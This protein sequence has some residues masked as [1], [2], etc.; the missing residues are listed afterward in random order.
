MAASRFVVLGLAHARSAW[1]DEVARW[2]TSAAL[3]VE[4]VKAMSPEEVR[5]RIRSGRGHSALLVDASLVGLDR[6]LVEGA[7]AAGCAVIVVL[8]GRTADA[9]E[10]LGASAALPPGFERDDLLSVLGQVA[11]PIER[12]GEPTTTQPAAAPELGYRGRLVAVTG[13][14]GTGVSTVAMAL[15]QGLAADPRLTEVT[16]LADLSLHADQA[17]LHRSDDVVPGL[18]ELVDAHRSG[19]PSAEAVRSLTWR[20]P[21]RGYRLLLGLR[22]HRDW[23]AVRPRA[24]AAALDGLR[25]SFR[26][27]VTDV[28]LDV[29]GEVSTGSVDIEER[30]TI[31]RTTLAAA[32][33]VVVIGRPGL[34]GMQGLLRSTTALHEHGISPESVL[35]VCNRAPRSP[36]A[37]AEISAAFG[38]LVLREGA[39]Q[40]VASPLHLPERR[41]LDEACH[42]GV[43]LPG[44]WAQPL[45]RAVE[46]LLE[47]RPTVTAPPASAEL[48]PVRPGSLGS[49]TDQD[50][51]EAG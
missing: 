12:L 14:G 31:A 13:P 22:R 39:D 46:A 30:N 45:V 43:P 40:R 15:A 1:F 2:A 24:F 34:T 7:Q 41:H 42:D 6:D 48:E 3:P 29:E 33:I 51:H 47:R 35:P 26:L 9:R 19:V 8:D 20:I 49:W 21:D 36:R 44:S 50:A 37:R 23:T 27:V 28:D 11:A 25:R 38:G 17:L 32:D 10:Q 18:L 5:V 16:C 4:F